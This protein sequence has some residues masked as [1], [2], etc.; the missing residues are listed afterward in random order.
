MIRTQ[1]SLT[2]EQAEEL[3]QR[4]LQERTSMAALIRSAVD[5]LLSAPDRAAGR[6]LLLTLVGSGASGLGNVSDEHDR[7]LDEAFGS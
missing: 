6:R 4:A 7:Y 3:R 1:I 2:E 5:R